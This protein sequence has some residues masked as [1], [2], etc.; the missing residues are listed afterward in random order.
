M[1][2]VGGEVESKVDVEEVYYDAG[3]ENGR[4]GKDYGGTGKADGGAH[5]AKRGVGEEN[6]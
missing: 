4:T 3:K 2:G 5:E 1:E 6:R